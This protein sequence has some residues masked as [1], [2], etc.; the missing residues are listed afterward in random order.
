MIAA[1]KAGGEVLIDLRRK[2]KKIILVIKDDRQHI[3]F[4]AEKSKDGFTN[5]QS[6]ADIFN[7]VATFYPGNENNCILEVI[8]P[9]P[10][11]RNTEV[12]QSS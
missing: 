11:G 5:I 12:V 10:K 7:G 4:A 1:Y 3:D 6:R 9:V 8:F 2:G